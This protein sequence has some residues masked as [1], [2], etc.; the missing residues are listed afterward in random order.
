MVRRALRYVARA[1]WAVS[2][3]ILRALGRRPPYGILKLDIE[4]ELSEEPVDSRLLGWPR[5][6][7][8]DYFT[9]LAML[10]WAREDPR[11]RGVLIRCRDVRTGWAKVQELRRSLVALRG[12]GKQVWVSCS[13][14]G[15]Q[16]Y[17]LASAADQIVLAPAGTL[18][19]AGLSSEVT[20][21]A[22]GLKKLGIEAELVQM[23]KYKSAAETFT[24]SDMSPAHR[25][26][27]ESLV[28]DLYDQVVAAIAS[29][30]QID[31]DQAR[32]LLDRGPFVAREA[33]QE[34][35]VDVLL[36]E[37]EAEERLRAQCANAATIET[38]DYFGAP[39]PRRPARRLAAR[40]SVPS[41]C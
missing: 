1:Y 16:E 36:Y 15:L 28:H 4:G 27:V 9:L 6:T 38:K 2:E 25:E 13:Q 24:R 31:A 39:A 20:F 23:G 34:R 21:V 10:R 22:G 8:D 11:L 7:R 26:M 12:K 32:A 14:A 41:A 19:I 29:G 37:D 18:D 17:V 3:T 40:A 35:L 5:R 30:R 33:Q